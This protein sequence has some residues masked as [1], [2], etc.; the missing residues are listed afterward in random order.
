MDLEKVDVLLVTHFH[1]DH[2]ACLP[3]LTEKTNFAGRIFMTHPTKVLRGF[4]L[5]PCPTA[6]LWEP[7]GNLGAASHASLSPA[8]APLVPYMHVLPLLFRRL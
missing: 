7:R 1:M 5:H 8:A 2:V 6:Y 4:Q 3:Y